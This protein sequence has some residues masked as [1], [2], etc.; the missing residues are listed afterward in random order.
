[1]RFLFAENIRCSN[2]LIYT[3][4]IGCKKL[5]LGVRR[6]RLSIAFYECPCLRD[7]GS[8]SHL[9]PICVRL[10]CSMK[11]II[12]RFTWKEGTPRH[13]FI[14]LWTSLKVKLT[15][16]LPPGGFRLIFY[17]FEGVELFVLCGS[18]EIKSSR[19]VNAS[20]LSLVFLLQF[21]WLCRHNSL[22]T[23]RTMRGESTSSCQQPREETG[24]GSSGKF[25]QLHAQL[26]R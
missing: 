9:F 15:L 3:K 14:M 4:Q 8:T 10:G 7:V 16:K 24:P 22:V 25:A 6:Y 2:Q 12:D 1:M 26:P 23:S 11:L 13:T 5:K 20:D 21:F 19:N 17:T 18:D